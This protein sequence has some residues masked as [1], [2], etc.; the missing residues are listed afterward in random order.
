MKTIIL[1]I[2]VHSIV[3]LITNSS[4]ELFVFNGATKDK[5]LQ[6][7]LEVISNSGGSGY[8]ETT[9]CKF[10]DYRYKDDYILPKGVNADDV[11]CADVDQNDS[12]TDAIL[13]EFFTEIS[14]DYKE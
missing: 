4:S 6:R 3:D 5:T 13:R 14:I 1:H 8:S 12:I 10:E 7:L 11:Y 2:P 9:I